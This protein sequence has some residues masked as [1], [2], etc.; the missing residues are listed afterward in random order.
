MIS[1]LFRKVDCLSIP[2]PDLDAALAFYSASLGHELIWRSKTAAGLKLPAS[3]AE[4]VLHTQNRPPEVDLAVDSVPE[5]LARFTSAG[6]RVIE[7]PFEIQIGLCAVVSDPWDN[8]LVILDASKG[9]LQV[10]ANKRVI[11]APPP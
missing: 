4:L 6:G 8:V 7:G 5:A 1:P 2:V 10:D 9:P 11:E 3:N